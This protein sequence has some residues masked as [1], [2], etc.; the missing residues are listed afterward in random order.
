MNKLLCALCLLTQLAGC[1]VKDP[2]PASPPPATPLDQLP[3]ATQTGQYTF[4]CLVNGQAWLPAGNP[5]A[6][7]LTSAGYA[8]RNFYLTVNRAIISN[9]ATTTQRIQFEIDSIQ[10]V[11]TY[12]LTNA[13]SRTAELADRERQ[14]VFVTDARHPATVQI[15]RLDPVARVVS[16][17]FSF[18]L[19]TPG[20]GQVVVTDGRFDVGF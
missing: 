2:Y 13:T 10:V 17:R 1:K 6:G 16:G 7:P 11:G 20:C 15:T 5:L 3:P 4:G 19:D 9:G 8:H 12:R 18:T 14:C